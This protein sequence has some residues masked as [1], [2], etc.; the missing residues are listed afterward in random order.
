MTSDTAREQK[1]RRPWIW[2]TTVLVVAAV[3]GAAGW[4]LATVMRPAQDPLEASTYTFAT[5]EAGE[6]TS[7]VNLNSIAEWT[8]TPIGSNQ[9]AGIVTS[10]KVAPGDEVSQGSTLYLVNQ[11]PIVVAEGSVP[12][13]R[14]IGDGA[15]GEDVVQLQGMLASLGHFSGD[16]DGKAGYRT[17][18]AIK[19]WQT[20]MGVPA[21]GAVELGDVIYVPDLPARVS[22]D[23]EVIARGK[24]VSG[25]EPVLL[26]LPSSPRFTLPVT[27]AQSAMIP[28]GTPVQ[29]TSPGGNAWEAVAGDRAS[30]AQSQ[31][32]VVTLTGTEGQTIC[33]DE[34]GEVPVTGEALLPSKIII[35]PTVQGL[36]VPSSA[37]MTD[38]S[39]QIVVIDAGGA[40]RP[41]TVVA[42][43]RGM[44]A[45]E[46]VEAGARVRIPAEDSPG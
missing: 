7:S 3:A 10:V 16:A 24:S 13:Y 20:S 15:E 29:I 32:V 31:A 30:E 4:A 43:A 17:V 18:A 19:S 34:C 41:V 6:I 44:S 5:V 37:L 42:S 25:G 11:R 9:A 12:A 28:T 39:G 40:R 27:E 22:V 36:V 45:I 46:G 2:T 21:T 33:A 14:A 23:D 35:V 26:G 38:V 1:R 8:P